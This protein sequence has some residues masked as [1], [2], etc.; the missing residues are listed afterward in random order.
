M[1]GPSGEQNQP[2]A[3]NISKSCRTGKIVFD[4]AF[5]GARF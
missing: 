5:E 1:T 3:A 4:N 2:S